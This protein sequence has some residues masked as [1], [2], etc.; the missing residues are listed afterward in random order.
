MAGSVRI[1][2][3]RNALSGFII[4]VLGAWGAVA[5]Y[6]GPYYGFGFT[7]DHAW[8]YTPGRLYLSA[9]PGAVAALTG[10]IVMLT[11]SRWFGSLCAFIAALAGVWFIAGA[12]LVRLLPASFHAG[13]VQVG[14]PIETGLTRITLTQLGL[15]T[16]VG[17]IIVFFAAIAMGRFSVAAHKDHVRA[18]ELEEAQDRAERA[19]RFADGSGLGLIYGTSPDPSLATDYASDAGQYVPGQS[20]AGQSQYPSQYPPDL[21]SIEVYPSADPGA[22]TEQQQPGGSQYPTTQTYPSGQAH[23]PAGQ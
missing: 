12:A 1:P 2:R 6:A 11:R 15:Y 5:P 19:G 21:D 20:Y 18:A 22:T 14:T 9:I 8:Q 23:P 3:S 17:A 4:L 16:G 7:P 10:L 13:S